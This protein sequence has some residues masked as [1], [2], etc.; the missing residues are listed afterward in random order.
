MELK[1]DRHTAEI[2]GGRKGRR[3]LVQA[4]TAKIVQT[5]KGEIIY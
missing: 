1:K 4:S 5:T 3:E 2:F